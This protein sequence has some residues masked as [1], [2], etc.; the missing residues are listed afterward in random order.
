MRERGKPVFGAVWFAWQVLV[1]QPAEIFQTLILEHPDKRRKQVGGK[2]RMGGMW[3]MTRWRKDT[4]KKKTDAKE[5]I[6]DVFRCSDVSSTSP[7]QSSDHILFWRINLS[8][9]YVINVCLSK[10]VKI[11]S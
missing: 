10:I 6:S 4:W 5:V 1:L 8:L 7:P 11:K 2:M 9:F 3:A